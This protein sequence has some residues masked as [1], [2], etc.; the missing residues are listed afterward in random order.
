MNV[1]IKLTQ[2]DPDIKSI[3]GL[4][5]VCIYLDKFNLGHIWLMAQE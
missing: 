2:K 1:S 5:E 3:S 4:L